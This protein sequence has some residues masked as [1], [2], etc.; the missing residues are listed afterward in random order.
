MG[1][2][3]NMMGDVVRLT[4]AILFWSII[5]E[6]LKHLYTLT[7]TQINKIIEYIKK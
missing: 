5:W 2:F 6:I 7:K 1:D 3:L 4:L